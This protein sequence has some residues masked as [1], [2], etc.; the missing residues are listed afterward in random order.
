MSMVG[1]AH[2]HGS[3]GVV[4]VSGPAGIGK[5][6]LL[7]EVCRQAERIR[8]RAVVGICD[9][10]DQ[11]SPGAPVIEAL[12]AG[13]EPLVSGERYEQIAVSAHEP[14]LLVERIASVLESAA[15]A[16]PVLV[17]I[18]D[19]QWAD[20]VSR[21]TIRAL[22]SRLLGLPVGCQYCRMGAELRGRQGVWKDRASCVSA[23]STG[24]S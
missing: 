11:V 20:R 23:S 21:F 6:A 1:R 13:R 9:P 22:L 17:A 18:D 8:M 15:E 19:V 7:A 14:L 10:V 4:L 24:S 2:R 3:G 5:S 16:G 12:R